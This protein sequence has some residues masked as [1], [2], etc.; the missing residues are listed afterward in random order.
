MHW[1]FILTVLAVAL[2]VGFVIILI[3]E[4][5]RL[6]AEIQDLKTQV[7]SLRKE[8]HQLMLHNGTIYD[9]NQNLKAALN[10]T[11]KDCFKPW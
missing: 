3:L 4:N 1:E 10:P 7:R 2:G 6:K 9:E 11:I 5:S 8:N